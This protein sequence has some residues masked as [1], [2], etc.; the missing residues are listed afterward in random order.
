MTSRT[1]FTSLLVLF[2]ASTIAS[3]SCG[4]SDT[5]VPPPP[6]VAT[7]T[8]V[9]SGEFVT[10]TTGTS[11]TGGMGGMGG[12]GG[13]GGASGTGG[14]VAGMES[15]ECPGMKTACQTPFCAAGVCD[16]YYLPSGAQVTPQ[17]VGD[18]KT[19]VCDGAGAMKTLDD[20][21]DPFD[22]KNPCT[23]D[24]CVAGA[25]THAASGPGTGCPGPNAA[26]YFCDGKGACVECLANSDCASNVC[27][28]GHC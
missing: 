23:E 9:T 10:A 20:D 6:S 21:L 17:S 1:T 24:V 19:V 12:A 26:A 22:D 13:A 4:G 8:G 3:A 27:T 11:G 25:T 7:S 14:M 5:K 15:S 18:C 28:A 2:A 16:F